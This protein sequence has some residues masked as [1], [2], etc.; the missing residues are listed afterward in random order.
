MSTQAA[1]TAEAIAGLQRVINREHYSSDSDDS[2]QRPTNRGHKLKRKAE[3]VREGQLDRPNGLK[4]YKKK[5]THAGFERAI[6]KRNPRRY[7][8]DGDELEDDDI[9]EQADLDAAAHNPY[10]HIKLEELLA[11]LT[12]A[13]DLPTHPSLSIPYRSNTVTDMTQQACKMVHREKKSLWAVK[14][15]LTKFRGD[16]AYISCGSLNA[17]IDDVLFNTQDVY[18]KL[19]T[20]RAHL[21]T[22]YDSS[23]S[24]INESA[25]NGM[26]EDRRNGT[27]H[28]GNPQELQSQTQSGI[29]HDVVELNGSNKHVEAKRET[30]EL[31]PKDSATS[32]AS[33]TAAIEDSGEMEHEPDIAMEGIEAND[34]AIGVEPVNV[35]SATLGGEEANVS[36]EVLRL[37]RGDA[38][39]SSS[40]IAVPDPTE[41]PITDIESPK[42]GI[43]P[44]P[45]SLKNE[46]DADPHRTA[47]EIKS[48]GTN[49]SAN[50]TEDTTA[51]GNAAADF[52]DEAKPGPHRMTTRAQAQAVSDNSGSSRT[53][54]PSPTSW[55]PPVIHP[56]FLVPEAA[57]P[58]RDFGLPSNEAEETRRLLM[59]YVQKQEEVV[60]GVEMLY[61]GLLRAD[62]MRQ[63]VFKWCKAE[64]HV[65]EMSDGEDWYDKEEW[66]LE[67]DLKKG[68]DDEEE[69]T[70]TQGKKTRKTRQ[71]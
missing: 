65:G 33:Q 30:T 71:Q 12:S 66:G 70:T 39:H 69:D 41:A 2:I 44:S 47:D 10:S 55:I 67:E 62:R 42:D 46:D 51:N 13:A 28:I 23:A 22:N 60:R 56:L 38:D 40:R 57:R 8:E 7:D 4:V 18:N 32:Q 11:P 20:I 37:P 25:V 17:D 14:N 63:T 53:R 35:Q 29:I 15:L 27:N 64:G 48:P 36:S 31:Q 58:D 68:H 3:Y 1:L 34:A 43:L 61:E 49:A 9:D 5:I 54:T 21:R 52:E 6:L 26:W 19:S 45:E 50:G 24:Q 16:N 59:A